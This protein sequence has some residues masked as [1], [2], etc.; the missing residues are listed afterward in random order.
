MATTDLIQLFAVNGSL[1]VLLI[2]PFYPLA[3]LIS[4]KPA[5]PERVLIAM[6]LGCSSQAVTGLLWSHLVKGYPQ[7]QPLS[8]LA[9]ILVANLVAV[10]LRKYS[11]PKNT[12]PVSWQAHLSLAGILIAAFVVRSLHPLSSFALG[13][14]DAYTHLHYVNYIVEQGYLANIVY[15][16]GYHWLLAL[17]VLLFKSDP[18]LVARFCGAFF[19]SGLVLAL[20]V[21][22]DRIGGRRAAIFGA[23]CAACFPGMIL[24]M[25]TGVGAFANQLGLFFVPCILWSLVNLLDG[26]KKRTA[27]LIFVSTTLGI[28]ASVPMMLIHIFIIIGLERLFS[29]FQK[30]KKW[31]A[32]TLFISLLCM[33]SILLMAFHFTQAGPN[34]RFQTARI[35]SSYSDQGPGLSGTLLKKVEKVEYGLSGMPLRV[36]SLV[37]KS[38]YFNLLLDF[39]SVKRHGF[40]NA[41]IDA[42]AWVLLLLFVWCSGYAL[43]KGKNGLL[44]LGIWG[45]LTVV[46]ASTGYLQFTSYQREG[47]SLLIAVSG[48][49]GVILALIYRYLGKFIVWRVLTVLVLMLSL[50]WTLCN[51]PSHQAIMSSAEDLLIRTVRSVSEGSLAPDDK[52]ASLLD[53]GCPVTV[54]SRKF[55][56]WSNQGDLMSNVLPPDSNLELVVVSPKHGTSTLHFSAGIQYLVLLDSEPKLSSIEITSAFAMVSPKLVQD[57]LKQRHHLYGANSDIVDY[58]KSLDRDRWDIRQAVLSQHLT[59]YVV[60]SRNDP[61]T[62]TTRP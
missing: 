51:P 33:P 8:Y 13:Q 5:W 59:A 57:V 26:G 32:T 30:K 39:V 23:F 52:L 54:V 19:G 58:I 36:M 38:P 20:Y 2:L 18:Y 25:K 15:P 53:F 29:C 4:Q 40:S 10:C 49:C 12:E 43:I 24:L 16:S 3:F 21:F 60:T 1:I 56:G 37:T 31:L 55:I 14:S 9:V 6:I 22:L 42:M 17:P 46:Q 34:Q 11:S 44:V 62:P 28:A 61:F 41:L 35:L 47:W 50:T 48:L 45:G 27:V 7:W